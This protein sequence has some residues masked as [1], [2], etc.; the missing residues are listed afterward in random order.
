MSAK[1]KSMWKRWRGLIEGG[2][3]WGAGGWG[4]TPS[5]AG[6]THHLRTDSHAL[7]RLLEMQ[8]RLSCARLPPL[9]L[10]IPQEPE[11][12]SDGRWEGSEEGEQGQ[13]SG[14]VGA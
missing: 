4:M 9:Y 6:D 1:H 14:K 7:C 3:R 5:P 2:F 11:R 13:K 10:F 12:R 8:W